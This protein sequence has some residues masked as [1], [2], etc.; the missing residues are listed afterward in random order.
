MH[1]VGLA[2]IYAGDDF[3]VCHLC[4][5]TGH[6]LNED[7]TYSCQL[8]TF[9]MLP[10]DVLLD[11]FDFYVDED[12]GEDFKPQRRGLDNAGTRVSML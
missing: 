12:M 1:I 10:D 4:N 8:I 2:R 11:V 7:V 6:L 5:I 3:N 9:D